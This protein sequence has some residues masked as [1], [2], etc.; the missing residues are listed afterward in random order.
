MKKEFPFKAVITF[1]VLVAAGV[2]ITATADSFV[3]RYHQIVLTNM[4]SAMVGGS[5]AFFL[6]KMF[7]WDREH[8][9]GK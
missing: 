7:R 4:G 8:N 3:T 1:A 2:T 5:L 6:I 9:N